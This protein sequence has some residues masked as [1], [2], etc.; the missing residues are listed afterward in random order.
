MRTEA[1]IFG[2]VVATLGIIYPIVWSVTVRMAEQPLTAPRAHLCRLG[3][4]T[5]VAL[6][7]LALR[8][9]VEG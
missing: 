6:L 3:I 2:Y 8:I 4:A 5:L 1:F 7:L 9:V